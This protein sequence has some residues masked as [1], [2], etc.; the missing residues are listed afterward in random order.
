MRTRTNRPS[1]R[2]GPH[3]AVGFRRASMTW[4]K[5][6]TWNRC[7]VT[8]RFVKSRQLSVW[9]FGAVVMA[10]TFGICYFGLIT[11]TDDDDDD[12]SRKRA[13]LHERVQIISRSYVGLK[14][15]RKTGL[16]TWMWRV[17]HALHCKVSH[18]ISYHIERGVYAVFCC[19]LFWNIPW[20][21]TELNR[22]I[23]GTWHRLQ[24]KGLQ[25]K[26]ADRITLNLHIKLSKQEQHVLAGHIVNRRA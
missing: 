10:C 8:E 9:T 7:R 18:I 22:P 15:E 25:G 16:I 3:P 20:R 23:H 11:K 4:K 21:Y 26:R 12:G 1:T 13:L 5:P 2:T 6:C 19:S 17:R 24:F 14:H